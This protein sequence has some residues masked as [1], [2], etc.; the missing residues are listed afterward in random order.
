MI[1]IVHNFIMGACVGISLGLSIMALRMS[2]NNQ[3]DIGMLLR[4]DLNRRTDIAAV[5]KR[6]DAVNSKLQKVCKHGKWGYSET[7]SL[8]CLHTT[9]TK[10]CTVCG[11]S[12]Q[13]DDSEYLDAIHQIELDSI[14]EAR[15]E[16]E[17]RQRGV[18]G[19]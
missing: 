3:D 2:R 8:C 9:R 11:Y 5:G 4:F 10:V 19:K 6:T 16:L 13:I 12:V 1:D 18:V 17:E 15:A 14:E 7:F